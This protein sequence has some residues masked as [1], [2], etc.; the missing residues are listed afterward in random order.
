METNLYCI[1]DLGKEFLKKVEEFM[2]TSKIS[3]GLS[4]GFIYLDMKIGILPGEL[5]LVGG[6]P[7]AGKSSFLLNVLYNVAR[8]TEKPVILFTPEMSK[9]AVV[10][11]LLSLASNIPIIKLRNGVLKLDE[12]QK[13]QA[14][15]EELNNNEI[16]ICD[17]AQVNTEF[18][19]QKVK[20]LKEEKDIALVGVDSLQFVDNGD[21]SH[22]CRQLKVLA[23][24]V[25]IPIIATVLLT[26]KDT[27][28]DL[29]SFKEGSQIAPYADII[30]L[31]DPPLKI[32]L[33]T[34]KVKV[35]KHRQSSTGEVTLAFIRE[36][37]SFGDLDLFREEIQEEEEEEFKDI[38]F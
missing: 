21:I 6:K 27:R 20:Q 38:D 2:K 26:Q 18:I 35:L 15:V 5:V 3:L 29:Q 19:I 7:G 32:G 16:Y 4:T 12:L 14:V 17:E 37:G 11:K 13:L 30:L 9:E 36:T 28:K 23:K 24:E 10:I 22:A 8:E 31:L 1:T 33:N 25:E 34:I